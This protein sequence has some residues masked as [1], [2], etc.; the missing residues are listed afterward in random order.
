MTRF[1]QREQVAHIVAAA[2]ALPHDVVG[3]YGGGTTL[4]TLWMVCQ[5]PVADL[6]PLCIIASLR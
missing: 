2:I 6:A 4:G 5:E 1:A 3:D